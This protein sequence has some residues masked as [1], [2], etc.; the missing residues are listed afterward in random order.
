MGGICYTIWMVRRKRAK[1]ADASRFVWHPLVHE[2]FG[3]RLT[4]FVVR[5]SG[6]GVSEALR[7]MDSYLSS[8]ELNSWNAYALYGSDDLIIR[9]WTT[10]ESQRA[11]RSHLRDDKRWGADQF[12]CDTIQYLW[13][14]PTLDISRDDIAQYA[15]QIR[16]VNERGHTRLDGFQPLQDLAGV[17]LIKPVPGRPEGSI[18]L[19]IMLRPLVLPVD[20]DMERRLASALLGSKTLTEVTLHRSIDGHFLI[21]AISDRYED[22]LLALEDV[23]RVAGTA[24]F[25]TKTLLVASSMRDENDVID[26]GAEPLS[27]ELGLLGTTCGPEVRALLNTAR[28]GTRSDLQ[29]LYREYVDVFT[30]AKRSDESEALNA[31]AGMVIYRLSAS[32]ARFSQ[33]ASP[34]FAS[35]EGTLQEALPLIL[36][37]SSGPAWY[38]TLNVKAALAEVGVKSRG[39]NQPTIRDRDLGQLRRLLAIFSSTSDSI[40]T[41]V[42]SALGEDWSSVFGRLPEMRNDFQHG[43]VRED[44][45]TTFLSAPFRDWAADFT[46]A[47]ALYISARQFRRTAGGEASNAE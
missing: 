46:A 33:L 3:Q 37:R 45:D 35:L 36:I 44:R 5:V 42:Q 11:I 27:P 39:G 13:D 43:R 10:V 7:Y 41:E 26:E 20:H 23:E 22:I 1:K 15:S 16:Q 34:L 40:E 12:E 9:C 17:G 19:Y 14:P 4:F 47:I 8:I 29:V 18:K 2:V 21:K 32:G 25:E 38:Q 28:D 6:V 31:L 30:D 24:T